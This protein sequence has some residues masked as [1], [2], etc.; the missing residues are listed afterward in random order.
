MGEM[1]PEEEYEFYSQLENMV[2]QGPARR[3]R[4]KTADPVPVQLPPETLEQVKA[5]AHADGRSVSS[6]I[7]EAVNRL[8]ALSKLAHAYAPAPV[9][10][11][12]TGSSDW[13]SGACGFL[14]EQYWEALPTVDDQESRSN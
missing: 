14:A 1:T 3:R 10:D 5:T 11:D 9:L 8:C 12:P 7:R 2:P 13:P 4:R 6:W